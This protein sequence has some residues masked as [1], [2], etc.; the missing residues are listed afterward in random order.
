MVRVK[1]VIEGG[2]SGEIPDKNFRQ[3]WAKFF[4]AAGLTGRMPKTVRGESRNE[5]FDKFKDELRK[6][7]PDEL[8]LL[9]VDS[10]GPVAAGQSAW[11]HL[12]QRDGWERPARADADS[13]YLM[14]QFMETWFLA[15]REAMRRFFGPLFR[16]S[17]LEAW[18]QLENVPRD[19]VMATLQQ[20]TANCQQP[21]RKG[22]VSFNLLRETSPNRVANACPH[23][24][25]L[26]DYLRSL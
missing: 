6:R 16:E 20:A 1:I 10:E 19:R 5:T 3:A 24:K 21:Y 17:A 23:A 2:G 25:S 12:Q 7:R 15:D 14:V 26:L 13:A 22:R 9:L 4:A 11:E 18:P 8:T